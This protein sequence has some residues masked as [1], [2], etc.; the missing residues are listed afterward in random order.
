MGRPRKYHTEQERRQA[1]AARQQAYR[2]RQLAKTA[3]VDRTA[4]EGLLA[5]VE[6]AA[7]AGDPVAR[8]VRG[9]SADA[10]LRN[11]VR[12][13]QERSGAGEGGEK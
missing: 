1:A 7:A 2:L 9:G 13:F 5:A 10:L 8:K 4:L 11:L 3:I 12:W 6:A